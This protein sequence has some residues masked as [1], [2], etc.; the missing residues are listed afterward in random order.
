MNLLDQEVKKQEPKGKKIVLLL[1]ILSIFALIMVIVMMMALSG[2]QTKGLTM[3]VN[4]VD[5][6]IEEGLFITDENGVDYISIQKIA[7]SIGYNYLSGEY[8][9]YSE[10]ITN[11]K[12]YLENENQIIEFEADN[13]I[14]NKT[15]PNSQLDYEEYKIKNNILK[16][17]GL[18]YISV[19]DMPIGLNATYQYLQND[20][21]IMIK[22]LETLNTEY[23]VSLPEQTSNAF[24]GV[25]DDV[26]N[27]K[28]I[29]YNMLVVSNESGKWG[30][31][32]A[33]NFSTKIGNKYSSMQFI[34]QQNAFI[35]SDNNKYGVIDNEGKIIIDLNYEMIN[36]INNQPLL[37]EVKISGKSFICNEKGDLL[38]NNFYDSFGYTSQS[39][40]EESV[41]VIKGLKNETINALVVVK[42]KKYGLL[43]LADG[44]LIADCILDK[45]YLKTERGTKTYYVQL[46]EQEF[47]LDSYLEYLNTTTVNIG[48]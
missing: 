25:S 27:I 11:T 5:L 39:T 19:D 32:N 2:K 30:V 46:Q 6:A 36:I 24:V 45:V 12:C 38:T 42:D 29:A 41:L 37:Y 22:T 18:L 1:L 43:N 23:K 16:K 44:T 33:S 26:N 21:Q 4:G 31:V 15:T 3:N 20:N 40:L 14:I 10:D 28:A 17:N 7:K 48:E 8:K 47:L 13:N 35:V 34:E 9:Q